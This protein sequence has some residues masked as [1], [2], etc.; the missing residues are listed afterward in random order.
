MKTPLNASRRL[1]LQQSAAL[2]GLGI[3]APFAMN[4]AAIGEAAAQTAGD[5]KALVCIF[6]NGGND[7]FNTVL[8]TDTAS[9]SNYTAV[10]NQQPDSLALARDSLLPIS[11]LNAQGR[12]FALHPG[13]PQTQSLFNTDKRIAILSNVGTLIEPINTKAEYEN[14]ARRVPPKLFSHNDQQTTWQALGPEGTAHGWG[15]RMADMIA[16]GNGNSLFTAISATGNSVWLSGQNVKQYQVAAS[17]PVRFGT[18]LNQQ[19]VPVIH[20]TEQ[21]AS[22]LDRIV[23]ANAKGSVFGADLATLAGRSID[24]EKLLSQQLPAA[25][26]AS[27]GTSDDLKYFSPLF[28]SMQT[29][30]LAEQLKMVARTIAARNGLGMKRQVFFVNLY[31][32]DT[33]DNQNKNHADLMARVD[34]ALKYFDATLTRLGVNQRVTTFTAS[35]FGRTFTSNGDGS[36]HGWGAHHLVMGGAVKGGDIYGAFPTYGAKN[37]NNN[38][39]DSS[40]DQLMN[41]ALLPRVSVEQYGATLARWFGLNDGQLADVFPNLGNFSGKTNLGFMRT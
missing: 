19:G 37:S 26:H 12:T 36:D 39:F 40:P 33:H 9:W 24:A 15:G 8:A 7:S 18:V 31:G 21:V 10:R 20:N 25:N 6:L 14:K 27:L 35:D 17:G 3:A 38:Q 34:H 23:R 16:S 29:S 30:A 41:G 32:F 11:P 1:F 28:N 13:L 2:S 22:A 5:Y 4:L